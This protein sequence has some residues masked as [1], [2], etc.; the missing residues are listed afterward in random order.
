[1]LRVLCA[2]AGMLCANVVFAACPFACQLIEQYGIS[3][4]GFAKP[5]P[6]A[7]GNPDRSARAQEM[8]RIVLTDSARTVNDGFLHAALIDA[9]Q[10]QAW[11]LRTGGFAGVYEWYGPVSIDKPDL[12]GC[13][14]ER[15]SPEPVR[16]E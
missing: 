10:R 4:S 9:A 12:T 7:A 6:R 3:F 14:I 2:A 13:R 16:Q 8:V 11:I 5:L 1:M 15:V